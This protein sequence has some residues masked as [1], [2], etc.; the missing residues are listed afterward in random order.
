[1]TKQADSRLAQGEIVTIPAVSSISGRV[2]VHSGDSSQRALWARGGSIIVFLM[3]F[4]LVALPIALL[5]LLIRQPDTAAFGLTWV[6]IT[7]GIITELLAFL[8]AY[9]LVR[10]ILEPEA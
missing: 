2:R 3:A 4:A 6:W 8:T 7:M 9:G 10:S 5:I 1:M